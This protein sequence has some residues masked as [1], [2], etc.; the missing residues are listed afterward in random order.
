MSATDSVP[1]S[2]KFGTA[3]VGGIL[4]WICVHPFNTAAVR[5]NL[6]SAQPGYQPQNFFKFVAQ[7][8]AE[9]GY[10]SLYDGLSA[11]CLRQVFYAT[12][13]FGLFETFRDK[14]AEHREIGVP[15][16]LLAGLSSGACAAAISCP[17]EVTLVR[18]SNDSSLPAGERRN[19]TSPLNAAARIA[20][21][22]GVAAFWSG[23]APFV[24]RA[25]LV[26]ICQV[27]T[28]DQAKSVYD[29]YG[30]KRGTYGNVFCASMTSGFIYACV[31]MPFESA[32]NRMAFQVPDAKG[33]LPYR[34]TPQTMAAVA[35]SSGVLSLW[36]GFL[37]Y[38][39]RCGGHTVSMFI[40]VEFLRAQYLAAEP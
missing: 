17:C 36:N 20:K 15:E 11:G 19:Y 32:K 34:T 13:R 39:L 25:M 30:I 16:R 1:T 29:G 7:T 26:G 22:E 40:F 3:G 12:S 35:S 2:V 5:M 27:G 18:M 6:A 21:E 33:V 31:T 10:K 9:K 38:Y 28:L 4:G 23:C 14:I 24:Q 8:G 37:P